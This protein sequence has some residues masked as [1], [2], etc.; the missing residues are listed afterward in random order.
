MAATPAEPARR[1]RPGTSV[2][3]KLCS[4]LWPAVTGRDVR[5]AFAALQA[6]HR[7]VIIEIYYRGRSVSE[8]ADALSVPAA[9]VAARAYAAI[10]Q[11]QRDVGIR[12][13]PHAL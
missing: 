8:T 11:L 9:T 7:Q 2:A 3:S 10:R 12:D 4:P 1:L 5:S 13:L 6:E